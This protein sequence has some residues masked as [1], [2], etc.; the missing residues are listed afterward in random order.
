MSGGTQHIALVCWG[1]PP[2]RGSGTFR[3]LAIANALVAEGADVTVIAANREVFLTHYGA[4]VSLESMI[5]PRVEVVRIPF[6]PNRSWP[7]VNDWSAAE[8][9]A[10]RPGGAK[11]NPA[12]RIF[13]ELV[14]S[15]W[16]PRVSRELAVL[17]DRK[18]I[19]VLLGTGAPY[20]DLEAAAQL[21]LEQGIPLIL[22]DRDCSIFD[23][24]SGEQS[25]MQAERQVFFERW[26]RSCSEMWFV[27]P[28]IAERVR[29]LFPEDAAKVH[30]VENGWD[31]AAVEPEKIASHP[32]DRIKAAYIG[33]V[34][35]KFPLADVI[36]AWHD[37]AQSDPQVEPLRFIGALGFEVDSPRWRKAEATIAEAP[38]S[39]WRGHVSRAELPEEYADL[40]VLIFV[41]EGGE[42]VT[43]GKPYEYAAT[44]LPIVALVDET[45]D[46]LRVLKDYPRLYQAPPNDPVAAADAM[47]S[48]I[49]DRRSDDGVR[50][51]SAQEFGAQL[52]RS[53]NL[54]AAVNRVLELPRS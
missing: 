34:A 44:G 27:N 49:E 19:S 16:L 48:A 45:S 29:E 26:L 35:T 23:V 42:Y 3:P 11:E 46:A 47:R 40:D 10:G 33:L 22:D 13:P 30:V 18:P 32:G 39:E 15:E 53:A 52:S 17:N 25:P 24:Y 54:Q 37:V 20:V 21:H 38:N 6:F 28:P 7:L 2:F 4:D 5:D 43:G 9:A 50:L 1:F 41:K 36:K 8:A 31:S 51:R 12:S 14:Y